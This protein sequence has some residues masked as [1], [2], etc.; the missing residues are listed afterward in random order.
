MRTKLTATEIGWI[1]NSLNRDIA[2]VKE[3]MDASDD[4]SPLCAFGELYIEGREKLVNK[5]IDFMASEGKTL[6]VTK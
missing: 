6:Y 3:A 2:S 5:L 4:N 1:I